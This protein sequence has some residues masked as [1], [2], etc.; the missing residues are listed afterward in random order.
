MQID[1]VL[2]S[3]RKQKKLRRRGDVIRVNL[4]TYDCTYVHTPHTQ[5]L[6][7]LSPSFKKASRL[8]LEV[9]RL[10]LIEC[11]YLIAYSYHV[12]GT[13]LIL[14][15]FYVCMHV[16]IVE[17]NSKSVC[18]VEGQRKV[19][20]SCLAS[21]RGLGF[22]FDS[23]FNNL[24]TTTIVCSIPTLKFMTLFSNMMTKTTTTK[25]PP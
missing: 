9:A 1:F 19:F 25:T 22:C 8:V 20:I 10:F 4:L 15:A 18:F 16:C 17:F 14:K 3:S 13:Y 12:L 11:H 2:S 21:L 24:V 7:L 6:A 5:I 23:F